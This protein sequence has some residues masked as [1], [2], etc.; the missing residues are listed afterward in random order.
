MC[1]TCRG[2]GL[3]AH[4]A[5]PPGPS[6]GPGPWACSAEAG[7]AGRQAV[8]WA[9]R[10]SVRPGGGSG[11][12]PYLPSV[13]PRV[14]SSP[15]CH[16]AEDPGSAPAPPSARPAQ[17]LPEAQLLCGHRFNGHSTPTLPRTCLSQAGR[18]LP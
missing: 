7:W 3:P 4:P 2:G 13:L 8:S 5:G 16:S 12:A 14:T 15:S 11:Q 10:H 1:G 6:R 17:S 18:P 9:D